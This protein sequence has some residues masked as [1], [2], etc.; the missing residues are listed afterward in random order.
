MALKS[1][2]AV[3]SPRSKASFPIGRHVGDTLDAD[4]ARPVQI[5]DGVVGGRIGERHGLV[6]AEGAV[7]G[8]PLCGERLHKLAHEAGQVALGVGGV[9]AADDVIVHEA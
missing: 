9:F 7:L 3:R 1:R 2:Q 6:P 4:D 5:E 8:F